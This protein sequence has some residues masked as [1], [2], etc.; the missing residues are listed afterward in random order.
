MATLSLSIN[1]LFIFNSDFV[2]IPFPEPILW[3]LPKILDDINC[4][5]Y[6]DNCHLLFCMPFVLICKSLAIAK[7]IVILHKF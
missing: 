5:T 3:N 2:K 7:I 4:D 6:L 1:E